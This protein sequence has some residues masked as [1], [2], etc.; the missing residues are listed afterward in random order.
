M[1]NTRYRLNRRVARHEMARLEAFSRRKN[2]SF[3]KQ[4]IPNA[5]PAEY[6]PAPNC[7]SSCLGFVRKAYAVREPEQTHPPPKDAVDQKGQKDFFFFKGLGKSPG[8]IWQGS[9]PNLVLYYFHGPCSTEMF[10]VGG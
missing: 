3:I 2:R 4:N 9:P 10:F 8:I 1:S 7:V 6:S 5:L